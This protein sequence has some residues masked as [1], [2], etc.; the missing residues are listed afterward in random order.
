MTSLKG[1][2]EELAQMQ[3]AH[4]RDVLL[5]ALERAANDRDWQVRAAVDQL[6]KEVD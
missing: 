4:G 1:D 2:L 6:N 3:A 5:A